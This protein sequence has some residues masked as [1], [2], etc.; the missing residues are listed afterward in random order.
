MITSS[1]HTAARDV[2]VPLSRLALPSEQERFQQE[3]FKWGY[4]LDQAASINGS[5]V[6]SGLFDTLEPL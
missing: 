3:G 5:G 2:S 6:T 4:L 1:E